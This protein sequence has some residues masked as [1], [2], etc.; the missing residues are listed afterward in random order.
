MRWL[1]VLGAGVFCFAVI[2]LLLLLMQNPKSE[3]LA[4][5]QKSNSK[6]E[7]EPIEEPPLET[8]SPSDGKSSAEEQESSQSENS[9]K[10]TE[11][12]ASGN[13][14]TGQGENGSG[15]QAH[16]G[17]ASES[18]STGEDG[19]ASES[20]LG[21][22]EGGADRRSSGINEFEGQGT[23]EQSDGSAL[24]SGMG[25][26]LFFGFQTNAANLVFLIDTSASMG[27]GET[28]TSESKL[29]KVKGELSKC[30][31]DLGQDQIFSIVTFDSLPESAPEVSGVVASP[32]GKEAAKAW[33][34]KIR[35]GQDTYPVEA[36]EAALLNSPD[37]I[38]LVSDGD[39]RDADV[40]TIISLVRTHDCRVNSISVGK[41]ALTLRRIADETGGQYRMV[42]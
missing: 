36:F 34:E 29:S 6:S 28:L 2:L 26:G 14:K 1:I 33:I 9:G 24:P 11:G 42:Q 19:N 40:D 20:S 16:S 13:G 5:D 17:E 4:A 38:F 35:T 31:D 23:E 18:G 15:E 30:I 21:G 3:E 8:K 39:F 32:R 27:M 25:Q 7:T 22:Q 41:D 12:N 37:T 10:P